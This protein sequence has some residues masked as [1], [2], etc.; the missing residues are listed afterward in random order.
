MLKEIERIKHELVAPRELNRIKKLI[1][2]EHLDRMRSNENLAAIKFLQ[3]LNTSLY[4]E[5]PDVQI[6]AEE[7]TA[8]PSVTRPVY[9]NG[10]GFGG[11][12]NMGWMNDILAYMK[13]DPIYRSYAQNKLTFSI[14]YGM[15]ENFFLPFSHDDWRRDGPATGMRRSPTS[16]RG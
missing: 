12:W 4:R 11:K 1:Q 10:L 9:Q 3:K 6:I 14:T 15:S 7:S 13:H 5:F 2:R 8:W 16:E